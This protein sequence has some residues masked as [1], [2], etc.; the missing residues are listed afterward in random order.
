MSNELTSHAAVRAQQRSFS[1]RDIDLVVELGTHLN[2]GS[3]LLRRRDADERIVT[4]KAEITRLERLRN[5]KVVTLGSRV[6]TVYTATRREQKRMKVRG[7]ELRGP[8]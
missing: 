5:A 4:L 2:D 3:V 1:R 7:L 8:A 6:L